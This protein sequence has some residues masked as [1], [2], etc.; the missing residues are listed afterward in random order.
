VTSS[1]APAAGVR[2]GSL[3]VALLVGLAVAWGS[4][5]IFIRQGIVYGASPLMFAAVRYALSAAA[6]AAIAAGRREAWPRRGAAAASAAIG[7]TLVIG[8]YGGL[9]YWGEQFTTGGYASVLSCTAPILTV[10]FAYTLLPAE[11][12]GPRSLLGL[13]LGF[14]GTIV[15]VVP[16]LA[17]G[18][19]GTWEGPPFLI[20]AFVCAAAGTVLLRRY[21][22]GPQ[23]SWQIGVQFAVAA[24]LLGAASL[25]VP[26]RLSL[27]ATP[28]VLGSLAALVVLSSV[29]GYFVYYT[30]HH[31]VGPVRANTVAYLLP[32]V[33]IALGSGFFAEPITLF[34]IAGFLIVIAGLTLILYESSRRVTAPAH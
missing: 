25:L 8:A 28:G 18:P 9:L 20:A 14:G 31:R 17:G 6:F 15:L 29:G 2:I 27:P 10:A 11:R 21:G 16:E 3:D 26:G 13:A 32:L 34:E 24:L 23:G 12:L 7:G 30:L 33:G 1:T 5:Y 4:A 19:I 22:G